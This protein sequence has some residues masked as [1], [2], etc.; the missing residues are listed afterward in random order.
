MASDRGV[1]LL[2]ARFYRPSGPKFVS[3]ETLA[4]V[5]LGPLL[6]PL[7]GCWTLIFYISR[8]EPYKDHWLKTCTTS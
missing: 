1:S 2:G 4:M 5:V 7:L 3:S 8:T 6:F